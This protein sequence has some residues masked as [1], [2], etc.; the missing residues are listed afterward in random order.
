MKKTKLIKTLIAAGSATVAAVPTIATISGCGNGG[1][2]QHVVK[3]IS[4]TI[5]GSFVIG[6]TANGTITIIG[7]NG[8]NMDEVEIENAPYNG[9]SFAKSIN[10]NT[11]IY[12]IS[13]QPTILGDT[14]LI[15]SGDGCSC[16]TLLVVKD[17]T[18]VASI[19]ATISGSFQVGVTVSEFEPVCIEVTGSN[20]ANLN[21]TAI[22]T[23][24][25]SNLN[26]IGLNVGET[27]F[28]GGNA[29]IP[30]SGTPTTTYSNNINI[31]T[32]SNLNC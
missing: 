6:E 24:I 26:S 12:T 1:S 11:I 10:D 19:S 22:N 13:G 23:A 4:A 5:S 21:G 25:V 28:I 29:F 30:V 16:E 31:T 9:L 3:S 14:N 8:V 27:Y 15:I 18:P 7:Y 32:L 20:G 2:N 17:K